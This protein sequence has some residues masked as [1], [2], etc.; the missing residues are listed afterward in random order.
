MDIGKKIG[1][2]YGPPTRN[3][4]G[5]ALKEIGRKNHNLVVLDG[6][7]GN[8]TR[9]QYFGKENPDRFF[10]VGIAESDLVGIASGLSASGK[11]VLAASFACFLLCNAYDQIRMSIA[12]PKMNVKLVG[13]H[14][15]I[16]IGEDGPSQMAIEDIAL[17]SSLPNFTV[18]V[19]ADEKSTRA[20]TQAMFNMEGPVYMRTG[21]PS[22]PIIYQNGFGFKIGKANQVRDGKDVTIIA[23]GLM[24]SA[25][26]EAAQDLSEDGIE[27][28]VLDM[29][30]IKPL[31][32]DAIEKAARETGAIVS[33]E[34]HVLEGGLGSGVAR[35][36]A[37]RFP[38]P[39]AFVGI[40]NE[41]AESGEPQ[42][43]LEKYGLMPADIVA[44]AEQAMERK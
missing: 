32:E 1:L 16:S 5:E 27:A 42:E 30:T 25:A 33:A 23:C 19:P 26:L 43:L 34:E 40:K 21:R 37:E 7:V 12:F 14:S 39:M 18:L 29:H 36:V 31:D 3:A 4:F 6:D 11:E 2:E 13:S 41:Y 15:G 9:T 10:N 28:R 8:S 22:V 44:A 38:V 35:V 24:V 20:A 17:A